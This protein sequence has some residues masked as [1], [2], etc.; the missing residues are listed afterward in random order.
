[1][2]YLESDHVLCLDLCNAVLLLVEQVLHLLL[3]HLHLKSE[4]I[5]YLPIQHRGKGNTSCHKWLQMVKAV[6]PLQFCK[7]VNL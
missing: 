3:E 5:Q 1:M 2:L 6:I 7:S 4:S